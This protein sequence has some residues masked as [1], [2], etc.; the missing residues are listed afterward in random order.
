MLVPI[1]PRGKAESG[2]IRVPPKSSRFA[3]LL[4]NDFALDAG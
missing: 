4:F 3:G 2:F 1:T